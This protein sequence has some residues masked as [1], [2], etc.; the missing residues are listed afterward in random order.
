[1]NTDIAISEQMSRPKREDPHTGPCSLSLSAIDQDAE[2]VV[3]TAED[4]GFAEFDGWI[5]G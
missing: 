4:D 2:P 5:S 1:M 3:D